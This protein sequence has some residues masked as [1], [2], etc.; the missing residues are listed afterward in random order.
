MFMHE[1]SQL[2][3][4]NRISSRHW[5]LVQ[6]AHA[7]LASCQQPLHVPQVGVPQLA[8]QPGFLHVVPS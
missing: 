6:V 8:P 2:V 1:L 3:C 7:V 4:A 5:L